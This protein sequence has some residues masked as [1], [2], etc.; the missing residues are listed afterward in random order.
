MRSS[1]KLTLIAVLFLC[2]TTFT[3][4]AKSKVLYLGDSL[5]MGAFGR[6][7]DANMRSEKLE[8]YTYVAGGASPYYWLSRYEPISCSI[9]YWEKTPTLEKRVGYIR[10][11]PKVE[12]LLDSYKPDV[13]VV[14]TGVNL[15]A[16]L[17]S[18]RREKK[19][20][21]K[22]VETLIM[23][24]CRAVHS[25]GAHSYWITP[26]ESH[27]KRFSSDLQQELTTIMKR[28]VGGLGGKVFESAEVTQWTGNY[29]VGSD[30]IHYGP[31]QSID[32][33]SKVTVDFRS[34][35]DHLGEMPEPTV[36]MA[37]T[38]PVKVA[39][40]SPQGKQ[41]ETPI[42]TETEE[43]ASSPKESEK[44]MPKV[45]STSKESAVAMN[46]TE[47]A[48]TPKEAS[49][50]VGSEKSG[51]K[52]AAESPV[53]A[54]GNLDLPDGEASDEIQ[55]KLKLVNKSQIQHLN[56]VTYSSAFGLYEYEVEKVYSGNY[57]YDK[58][59]IAHMIVL[60]KKFT[61]PTKFQP[62]EIYHLTLVKLEKYPSL[63]R[64]QM[65]DQLDLN[66]DLPIYICKF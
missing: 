57:P 15:Y 66:L 56:E 64:V 62:G 31:D 53:R 44:E 51:T 36:V 25:K 29:P 14:Q 50:T 2:S 3:H 19:E 54:P 47:T 34:F 18:K 27:P 5:S 41:P 8:V 24:M 32:W 42:T 49:K 55:V 63:Q 48:E 60:N 26:P 9:G 22:L 20:N 39:A 10:A 12:T 58:L 16:T 45:G 17:R 30:G 23:D 46:N 4:A 59:R 38:E 6:T 43:T 40:A 28:V 13:V 37:A 52:A 61:G 7:L 35:I 65:I 33:A 11:V 21:V 1:A